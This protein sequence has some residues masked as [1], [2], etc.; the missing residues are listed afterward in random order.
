MAPGNEQQI[1][2]TDG[3]DKPE[4]EEHGTGDAAEA[5]MVDET[6]KEGADM[7]KSDDPVPTGGACS[8]AFEDA[9]AEEL[10]GE[11]ARRIID[12]AREVAA[13]TAPVSAHDEPAAVDAETA[14]DADQ[15]TDEDFDD[16]EDFGEVDEPDL[17][18][19]AMVMFKG[20]TDGTVSRETARTF[21]DENFPE[22]ND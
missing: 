16:D 21:I 20:L 18:H 15:T 17:L 6:L 7:G 2:Q 8:G 22:L 4:V 1:K 10:A 19:E 12:G 5:A 11:S 9:S 14:L 13:D 3:E